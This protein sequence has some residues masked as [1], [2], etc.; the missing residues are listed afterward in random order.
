MDIQLFQFILLSMECVCDVIEQVVEE[1][2]SVVLLR[3]SEE[4]YQG[5]TVEWV[6]FV[7]MREWVVNI[8]GL[9]VRHRER[10]PARGPNVPFSSRSRL[11]KSR[12]A[13]VPSRFFW[14]W[15]RTNS[16][17]NSVST[18]SSDGIIVIAVAAIAEPGR[19]TVDPMVPTS[20]SVSSVSQSVS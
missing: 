1:L 9:G 20:Q 17:F 10:H 3:C 13:T 8:H 6:D 7:G 2:V 19:E 12:G 16:C 11:M 18:V 5:C 4:F 15:M 14:L